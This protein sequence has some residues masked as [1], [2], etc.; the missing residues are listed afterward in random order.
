MTHVSVW[1]YYKATIS[2]MTIQCW[3]IKKKNTL[4]FP[5]SWKV[6]SLDIQVSESHNV[7][8]LIFRLLMC[9]T[10]LPGDPGNPGQSGFP[11][12]QGRPG[13]SGKDGEPGFRGSPVSLA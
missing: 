8:I 7:Q 12:E 5:F 4:F 2:T 13:L 10:G 3:I 11:G 6:A 9:N 1:T